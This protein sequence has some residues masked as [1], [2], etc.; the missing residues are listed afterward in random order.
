MGI[1]IVMQFSTT[2]VCTEQTTWIGL[3][4]VP[5][6]NSAIEKK[7]LKHLEQYISEALLKS[8]NS[9]LASANNNQIITSLA[10]TE[11]T[12]GSMP[13]LITAVT[14]VDSLKLDEIILDLDMHYAGNPS[15]VLK[16]NT[17]VFGGIKIRVI[18]SILPD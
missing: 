6:L 7:L 12:L 18:T 16:A 15:I 2:A 9:V 14:Y 17:R 3:C 8:L 13:P 5:W 10:F 11:I 1:Q 4:Q